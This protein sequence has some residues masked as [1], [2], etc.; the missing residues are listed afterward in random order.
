MKRIVLSMTNEEA[1]EVLKKVGASNAA[2]KQDTELSSAIIKAIKA[3]RESDAKVVVKAADRAYRR[4]LKEGRNS[5]NWVDIK[6]ILSIASRL[7]C[8]PSFKA[9]DK[10]MLQ[11][12]A[13]EYYN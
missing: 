7:L 1:I 13:D 8:K 5:L 2:K 9:E 12:I 6:R 3:L 10:Q 11:R 4:G